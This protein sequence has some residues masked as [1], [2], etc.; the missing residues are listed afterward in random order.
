[1]HIHV[2]VHVYGS[3]SHNVLPLFK[4]QTTNYNSEFF[5]ALAMLQININEN[6]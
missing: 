3:Q 5:S 1:M 4:S 6:V 2:H